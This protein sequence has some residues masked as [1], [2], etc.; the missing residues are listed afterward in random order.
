[1]IQYSR[2]TVI[3]LAVAAG[4]G[5][6]LILIAVIGLTVAYTG[7]Y[8]IAATEEHTSLVRWAFDTTFH[9]SVHRHAADLTAPKTFTEAEIAAGAREYQAMCEHCHAGSGVEA[10]VWASGMR[11]QPP[12]LTEAAAE[13]EM[14]EVFWLAKHG[15][16]M[17]GMP[18]FGP[19]HDDRTLWNIAAFVKRLPAMTPERYSALGRSES[20]QQSDHTH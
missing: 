11:P 3:S 16:K 15:A 18:A 12:H 19:T 8:N 14:A 13:W 9:N 17:T 5:G 2:K 20:A 10:E 4:A 7:T 6:L 1:M